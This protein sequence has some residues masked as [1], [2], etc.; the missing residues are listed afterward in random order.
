MG[1]E[2]FLQCFVMAG[3]ELES[4]AFIPDGNRRFARKSGVNF[5]KA[6]QIGTRKAWDV[7]HWLEE[8]PEIAGLVEKLPTFRREDICHK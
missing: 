2:S 5:L 1:G 4:I 7:M 6:Y 8:Y 3:K